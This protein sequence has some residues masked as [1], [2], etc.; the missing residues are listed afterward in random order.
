MREGDCGR[1]LLGID[2]GEIGRMSYV[3]I[4]KIDLPIRPVVLQSNC[5]V[6][7]FCI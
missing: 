1:M 2:K 5:S 6:F 4:L 3:A 7:L